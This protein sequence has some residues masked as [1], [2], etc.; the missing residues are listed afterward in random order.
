[1]DVGYY[2]GESIILTALKY[3][4]KLIV[5][6]DFLTDTLFYQTVFGVTRLIQY[7]KTYCH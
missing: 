2:M 6:N 4:V 3:Y 5:C 1:M 7:L